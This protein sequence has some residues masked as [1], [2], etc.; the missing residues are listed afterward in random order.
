MIKLEAPAGNIAIAPS[1]LSA[2]L[3]N[4]G[5]QIELI[6]AAGADWLHVD[7]MDGRFVPNLSF[8]PATVKWINTKTKLAQDVH[9]MVEYP[10]NFI[11]PFIKAGASSLTLH[12]ES[13]GNLKA[14]LKKVKEQG[15]AA[16]L[17]IKPDTAPKDLLPYADLIDLLLVMTVYP[18][19]GGQGFLE[20]G[21]GQIKEARDIINRSGRKIWL[22][23]DGGI[24]KDTAKTAARAGADALV[25][26]SAIFAAENPQKALEEIR[27]SIILK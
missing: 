5:A 21:P 23:V 19:F 7:V 1:I 16:G 20:N 4:L 11:E 18:G 8:G 10:E 9:L 17:S 14:L 2:D 24:N 13:K 6:Q 22:E 12:I 25:A 27:Q 15:V 3:L 26:G